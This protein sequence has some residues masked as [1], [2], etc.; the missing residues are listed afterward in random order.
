MQCASFFK[1]LSPVYSLQPSIFVTFVWDN[2]DINL[3]I[4]NET[5]MHA[6]NGIV[7]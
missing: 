7:V 3:E 6:T 1:E 2:N 5:S 4:L